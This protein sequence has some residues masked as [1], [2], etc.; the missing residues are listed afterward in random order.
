MQSASTPTPSRASC[1]QVSVER[2][3]HAFMKY[4]LPPEKRTWRHA[5]SA[6]KYMEA[7]YI[8]VKACLRRKQCVRAKERSY[9]RHVSPHP[10]TGTDGTDGKI[11]QRASATSVAVPYRSSD[12]CMP[13]PPMHWQHRNR[14]A[15]IA[16]R[17][18][19]SR[20]ITISH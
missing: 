9:H 15:C 3:G 16:M 17:R 12:E 14:T 8:G 11:R 20:Y 1:P 18:V 10:L 19:S 4:L 2:K 5:A 7:V 13:M 6:S